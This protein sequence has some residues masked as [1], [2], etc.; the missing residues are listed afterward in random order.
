MVVLRKDQYNKTLYS[1]FEWDE[2]T[3]VEDIE[4]GSPGNVYPSY[5]KNPDGFL[6]PDQFQDEL[7]TDAFGGMSEEI[8]MALATTRPSPHDFGN[9]EELDDT[10][11]GFNMEPQK[12][13]TQGCW[14]YLCTR[15]N[16]FSNRAQK[17][18]LCVTE[19]D[20]GDVLVGSGGLEWWDTT[21]RNAVEFW[22]GAVSGMENAYINVLTTDL[23]DV[24]QVSNVEIIEGGTI[25]VTVAYN[26]Q[27]LYTS[28]LMWQEE[29]LGDGNWDPTWHKVGFRSSEVNGNKVAI[30]DVS[31]TGTF[32]VVNE[33]NAGPIAALTIAV[34][35][36]VIA[37]CWVVARK[38]GYCGGTKAKKS[39][40]ET[41]EYA[42]ANSSIAMGENGL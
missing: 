20:V 39:P 30:A 35:G 22:P 10:G 5:V 28:H 8:M 21:G 25:T 17:G 9:L 14:N 12:V 11:T 6:I 34:V 24:V 37:L 13:T 41:E 26:T 4:I 40:K 36:F 18:K 19:G 31:E 15:N 38:M 1:N 33:P 16:N 27:A 32:K 3:N 42:N 2:K 7:I 29:D 23:T